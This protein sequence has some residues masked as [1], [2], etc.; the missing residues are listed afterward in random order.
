MRLAFAIITF[1]VVFS[2]LTVFLASIFQQGR[3]DR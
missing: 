2:G 1:F 3:R